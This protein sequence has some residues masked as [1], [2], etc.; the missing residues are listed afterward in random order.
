M[1]LEESGALPFEGIAALTAAMHSSARQVKQAALVPSGKDAPAWAAH[2]LLRARAR[3][4]EGAT[5]MLCARRFG[6]SPTMRTSSPTRTARRTEASPSRCSR[7][8]FAR[9]APTRPRTTWSTTSGTSATHRPSARSVPVPIGACDGTAADDSAESAALPA[10]HWQQVFVAP[11]ARLAD[12]VHRFLCYARP[13]DG[14]VELEPL[15]FEASAD[16]A[17]HTRHSAPGPDGGPYD[18]WLQYGE[19]GLLVLYQAYLAIL[20]G[21]EALGCFNA[22]L[23]VFI[24]KSSPGTP[25]MPHAAAPGNF[26][27]IALSNTGQKLIANVELRPGGHRA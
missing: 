20:A 2:W 23:L 17:R 14:M 21:V 3:H 13:P 16:V 8:P 25:G 4:T 5:Q 10:R 6:V 22:T 9:V 26:R 7:P 18:A 12:A 1:V 24:P 19:G 15:T 27:P 11:A